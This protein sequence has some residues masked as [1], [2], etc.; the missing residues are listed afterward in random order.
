MYKD[1]KNHVDFKYVYLQKIYEKERKRN[2]Q[3]IIIVQLYEIVKIQ[4]HFQSNYF[5][6]L[7]FFFDRC[8]D[9]GK[10]LKNEIYLFSFGQGLKKIIM[11]KVEYFCMQQRMM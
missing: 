8:V 3:D 5:T 2:L 4:M 7:F 10:K 1:K 9:L 11:V 6:S